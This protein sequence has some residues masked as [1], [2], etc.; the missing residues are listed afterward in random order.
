MAGSMRLFL[1]AVVALLALLACLPAVS[2]QVTSVKMASGSSSAMHHVH[3]KRTTVEEVSVSHPVHSTHAVDVVRSHPAAVAGAAGHA[4]VGA[5]AVDG[6]SAGADVAPADSVG[7]REEAA[8]EAAEAADGQAEDASDA[9]ALADAVP[10]GN[11]LLH[12]LPAQA[13][14]ASVAR[15]FHLLRGLGLRA[16]PFVRSFACNLFA[17]LTSVSFADVPL[18]DDS[19]VYPIAVMLANGPLATGGGAAGASVR[20]AQGACMAWTGRYRGLQARFGSGQTR[21][22]DYQMRAALYDLYRRPSG[23]VCTALRSA[24]HGGMHGGVHGAGHA[25]MG[26][27]SHGEASPLVSDSDDYDTY[28]QAALVSDG[29]DGAVLVG[30][31]LLDGDS[32]VDGD[33]A[34][35][36][37]GAGAAVPLGGVPA[38]DVQPQE[39][40]RDHDLLA[41]LPKHMHPMLRGGNRVVG[42]GGAVLAAGGGLVAPVSGVAHAHMPHCAIGD[43][44]FELPGKVRLEVKNGGDLE[45]YVVM[46][47]PQAFTPHAHHPLHAGLHHALKLGYE[48]KA[49]G[50]CLGLFAPNMLRLALVKAMSHP[51]FFLSTG[52]APGVQVVA[53]PQTSLGAS[54]LHADQVA[55]T[56]HMQQLYTVG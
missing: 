51:L 55:T 34:G 43:M 48:K 1:P 19:T 27:Y 46:A 44:R 39:G 11:A 5:T 28:D 14:G 40:F 2:A 4:V 20:L 41:E 31:G 7:D 53:T 16:A 12:P 23:R 17:G 6:G 22:V 49:E 25:Y 30:D 13:G 38:G 47:L 15:A 36:A 50:E 24:S 10:G 56:A 29:S 45:G 33:A 3:Q 8:E 52:C 21:E 26:F 54:P 42:A 9:A 32:L 35:A 18:T 37:A